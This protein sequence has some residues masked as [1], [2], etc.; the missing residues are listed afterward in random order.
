MPELKPEDAEFDSSVQARI[1]IVEDEFLIA[2][3]LEYRL[4]EAGIEVVGTAITAEEAIAIAKSEKPDLAIMDIRLA[5]RRDG[6]DAAIELYS[7][8]GIRSIFASAHADTDTRSRAAPA[9]PIG[10]LQKP[11]QAEELLRLLKT[12]YQNRDGAGDAQAHSE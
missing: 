6:V 4:M 3:E 10:W 7:T 11:Y 8:L 12:Y 5:G 1:L 2:M 9:S